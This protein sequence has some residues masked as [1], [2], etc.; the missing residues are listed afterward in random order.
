MSEEWFKE[1]CPACLAAN[2]WNNGDSNDLT[3]EDIA[4]VQCHNCGH[5]W[6]TALELGEEEC[7]ALINAEVK[8]LPALLMADPSDQEFNMVV[9]IGRPE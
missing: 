2:W 3:V 5:R 6:W 8:E 9:G 7:A 4:A 1:F